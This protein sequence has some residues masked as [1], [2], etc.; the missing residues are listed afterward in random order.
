MGKEHDIKL[1]RKLTVTKH[2]IVLLLRRHQ[3]TAGRVLR[4]DVAD[5]VAALALPLRL[6][7]ASATAGP[8][9]AEGEDRE[10]EQAG[11]A[12]DRHGGHRQRDVRPAIGELQKPHV[13]HESPDGDLRESRGKCTVTFI[14]CQ[15]FIRL[16]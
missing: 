13:E 10:A 7:S 16:V 15:K 12:D 11:D 6:L 8:V 2:L 3:E 1:K 5:A 4:T 14:S 9:D